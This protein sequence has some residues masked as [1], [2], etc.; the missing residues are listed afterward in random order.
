[1]QA[2]DEKLSACFLLATKG[3]DNM[4]KCLSILFFTGSALFTKYVVAKRM[5]IA[6]VATRIVTCVAFIIALLSCFS[7]V[8]SPFIVSLIGKEYYEVIKASILISSA[9]VI[10]LACTGVGVILVVVELMLLYIVFC[11]C[12]KIKK[13]YFA[14]KRENVFVMRFRAEKVVCEE[15]NAISYIYLKYCKYLS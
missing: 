5:R 15:K 11:A 6:T 12:I 9:P 4:T 13:L 3:G 10:G 2:D 7:G 8:V 14:T 1:M